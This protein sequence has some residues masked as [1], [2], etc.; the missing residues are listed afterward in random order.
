MRASPGLT[1]RIRRVFT[2]GSISSAAR[3][4][5]PPTYG[6]HYQW[7]IADHFRQ[8]LFGGF[9]LNNSLYH[10]PVR[11]QLQQGH[12]RLRGSARHLA[13]AARLDPGGGFVF[14]R[15]EMQ[16]TF[17]TDNSLRALS[18]CAAITTASIWITTSRFATACSSMP[19]CAKRFTRRPSCPARSAFRPRPD[20]PA[21]TDTRLNPKVSGA[22][23]LP[24]NG[25][26]TRRSAPASARPAAPIWP[27]PTT[28]RSGRNARESYDV[29]IEEQFLNGRLSLD[30]TW[31]RNRYR[32]LIVG[33][34]G[35][36]ADALAVFHR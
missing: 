21:R 32:D 12:S 36:L 8:D 20:F 13:R 25:A 30:A 6:F 7:D 35:S 14:D 23:M 9:F 16:N 2:P 27:S 17:V 5:T 31:F 26:C 3:R 4:T 24:G 15:E 34:G 18:C 33:L 28:P 11:R 1:A 19:A 22:Y 29:G 10:Q